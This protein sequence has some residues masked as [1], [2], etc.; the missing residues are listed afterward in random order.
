[1][2]CRD[3]RARVARATAGALVFSKGFWTSPGAW[4]G[5]RRS[6]TLSRHSR[7]PTSARRSVSSTH[8]SRPRSTPPWRRPHRS[9]PGIG[10]TLSAESW[11]RQDRSLRHARPT[12]HGPR[13]CLGP[14]AIR[15][16]P[17]PEA[18]QHGN[19]PDKRNGHAPSPGLDNNRRAN[20]ARDQVRHAS[21]AI[22]KGLI[23]GDR[24]GPDMNDAR[25]AQLCAKT[26]TKER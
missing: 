12:R 9:L 1:L 6:A 23:A 10:A 7:S 11:P 8:G 3:L 15:Q 13:S 2:L 18:H 25:R 20:L 24:G 4:A 21:G 16:G 17:L 22:G 19:Q 14:R 5:R 26:W